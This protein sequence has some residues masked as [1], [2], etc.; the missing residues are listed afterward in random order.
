MVLHLVHILCSCLLFIF[1]HELLHLGHDPGPSRQELHRLEVVWLVI[2]SGSL[3]LLDL[4]QVQVELLLL[5]A[6]PQVL[7]QSCK[8]SL[9]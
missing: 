5:L 3:V 8:G 9:K 1:V 6:R 7:G 2:K 4:G